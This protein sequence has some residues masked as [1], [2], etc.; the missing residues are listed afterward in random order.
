MNFS[1]KN[2]LVVTDGSQGMNSQVEGLAKQ[3][4]IN[5]TSLHAKLLFPWSKLQPGILP[6]FSWI[7][8]NKIN[9][10]PKPDLI[11]SCGRKSVYLSIYFKKKFR[12]IIT[13]HI[14]NP[15]ISFNNFNYIIA[16]QHDNIS[17]INVISSFGALHRFDQSTLNSVVDKNFDIPK[18]NLISV[19]IGGSNNHYN[20]SSIEACE[21][22]ERIKNIKKIN[23]KYIFL[24]I[25]S[26]R[27]SNQV[28]NSIKINLN[29]H[30]IISDENKK[31]PY[32][33]ALKHSKFFIV[34]SDS[35]SMI[36]ECAFTSKPIYIF[37]LPFKRK[38]KR[39][40]KF[41][42]QFQ[43]LNITKDLKLIN[44]LTPWTYKLLDESKRISSIIKKRI[45][46]EESD[47]KQYK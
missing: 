31:N 1:T 8:L 23:P 11:I 5:F 39:I 10:I 37:H 7:F 12:N 16:P 13:I 41:H 38:S 15:K 21:L 36:S 26:R 34:T 44:K 28:K 45:I 35:T 29:N 42:E 2:I 33:F 30:A 18:N 17:G 47:F 46:K 40:K 25:F 20:F 3:F 27:T 4:N 6:I 22:I 43:K 19:I 14:Q 24:I 32:T 9:K